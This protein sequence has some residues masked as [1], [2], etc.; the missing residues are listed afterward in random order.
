MNMKYLIFF[1]LIICVIAKSPCG[2]SACPCPIKP[3][4]IV[5]LAVDSDFKAI[6][7]DHDPNHICRDGLYALQYNNL[8]KTFE[9]N[10][11]IITPL[12]ITH[13][14]LV[15]GDSG[16]GQKLGGDFAIVVEDGEQL[17]R[18]NSIV[19]TADTIINSK[20]SITAECSCDL[21]NNFT[22]CCVSHP[23]CIGC[24]LSKNR[25]KSLSSFP[26][27]KYEPKSNTEFNYCS[28][29]CFNTQTTMLT[30]EDC[31]LD[32]QAIFNEPLF[33]CLFYNVS[34]GCDCIF[35]SSIE[36]QRVEDNGIEGSKDIAFGE[37]THN[38]PSYF[39][40]NVGI[41]INDDVLKIT[42]VNDTDRA[43]KYSIQRVS[44]PAE[45]FNVT[46]GIQCG[47]TD[48]E[49]EIVAS[50]FICENGPCGNVGCFFCPSTG[51][52]ICTFDVPQVIT[53]TSALLTYEC[54]FTS[55]GNC[56]RIDIVGNTNYIC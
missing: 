52:V 54:D 14:L 2:C 4:C 12:L 51:K 40:E 43:V 23:E 28:T 19:T 38:V 1:S 29:C 3:H 56:T 25:V 48:I 55:I 53:L 17:S 45:V 49:P 16:I 9:F 41:F 46:Y 10:V 26:S 8:T 34:E 6:K 42:I 22:Q 20:L 7:L 30:F 21:A 5:S 50:S 27:F 18:L 24:P 15:T 37:I 47:N 11:D 44:L 39:S 33:S 32:G 35:E 31:N 13:D 36:E